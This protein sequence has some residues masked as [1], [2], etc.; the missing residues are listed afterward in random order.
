MQK[1]KIA[2]IGSNGQLGTDIMKIFSQDTSIFLAPLTHKEIEISDKHSIKKN[3]EE[4]NPDIIINTAAY[5][6]VDDAEK[7]AETAFLINGL[8]NKYLA[9]YCNEKG[10]IYVYISSDYVFGTDIQRVEPYK[11]SDLPGPV[12][13]YGVSK[14][15][16]ELYVRYLC[17]KYFIVRTGGLFGVAG[18]S[19]KGGNFVELMMTLAKKNNPIRVV[20]D[21]IVS[22][23]YTTDLAKQI[24]LLIKTETF[25]L[26]HAT[27]ADEC[28][29]YT[30]TKEI[31]NLTKT[32][33]SLIAVKSSE[34]PTPAKRAKYSVL[35]NYNLKKIG[36]NIMPSWKSGLRNYLLEKKYI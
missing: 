36:V 10:I 2:L 9:N 1:K 32:N 34:F 21:Q 14:M 29:W 3:F 28:S 33:A 30:F 20:N 19:G 5:N 26:Y 24:L 11:E 4:I 8:A 6:R 25:G 12:N 22:P 13:A 17:E 7:E 35:D 27:A 18:S 23:T 31:F 15:A 16:G